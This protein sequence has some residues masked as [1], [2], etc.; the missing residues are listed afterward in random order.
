MSERSY[1]GWFVFAL[2]FMFFAGVFAVLALLAEGDTDAAADASIDFA[3]LA[4]LLG[5]AFFLLPAVVEALYQLRRRT[6]RLA[7]L[8]DED[9]DVYEIWDRVEV[10]SDAAYDR[11]DQLGDHTIIEDKRTGECYVAERRGGG[12]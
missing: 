8:L 7:W 6:G 12:E 3:N 9:E 2:V 1:T 4:M 10:G 11:A 5:I